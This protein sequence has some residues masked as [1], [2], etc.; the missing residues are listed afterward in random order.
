MKW[1]EFSVEAEQEAVESVSE[2]LATF[3]YNGG[4]AVEQPIIGSPDGPDYEVDT[5]VPVSVRTYIPLDEHA[6]DVRSRLEQG[7]WALGMIRKIGSL[8]IRTLEE[9]DWA[10]AWKAYYPIRRVGNH[11]VIVP[12]WLTYEPQPNDLVLSLDP[13]MAFGTGLHPTTQLSLQ[14]IEK[15]GQPGQ[16]TLDLGCGSGI[17]AIGLAKIGAASVLAVDNDPIAVTATIENIERNGT[18]TVKAVEGSLGEGAQ[19]PHWLGNDWGIKE[20]TTHPSHGAVALQP[21]H[22]FDLIVANILANVHVLI[23]PDLQRALRRSG[24]LITSGII[25]DRAAEVEQAFEAVGLTRLERLQEG[26]WVAFVH[27]NG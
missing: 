9:E 17:L 4:V 16:D 8:T 14:L 23:A 24:L 12:S 15:Y 11:W 10:N 6:E 13:G 27:R 2:L 5:T 26:D 22:A 25:A 3:G 19:L 1:L 18:T 21:E 20:R 7:L